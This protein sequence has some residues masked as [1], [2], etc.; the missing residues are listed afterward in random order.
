MIDGRADARFEA[1]R[2]AFAENFAGRGETGAAVCAFVGGRVV[3]DLWG[4]A[5]RPGL[6]WGPDTL[7]NV[8]SVGKGLT[9]LV[10]ARLAGDGRLDPDA[11]VTRYWPEFGAAG[12]E[13]VT[14]RH[15]LSHRAGL[16]A[17][18][19][20]LPPGAML[21][22]SAMTSALAGQEPWWEPGTAH[23]YHVNTFGFLVGEVIRRATGRTVG[24]LLR[25]E[26]CGPL[27]ADAF[28]G[29]PAA[30]HGRVAD[31]AWPGPPPPEDDPAGLDG[32]RLMEYN[33][34]FNPGGLSGA[35]VINSA[36]W[37][38]AELPST[39]AHASAR[40]VARVYAAL[41]AGGGLDGVRVVGARALAEATAERSAGRDRVLRRPSRFGS[42]FQLTQPER[43]LGPNLGAFG[44]YG[45]GGSLGFCDPAAGVAFGYVTNQLGPR[46][47]NPRN[48]ALVEA[49]YACL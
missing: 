48:R 6:P 15:L 10:A 2:A 32:D 34:Y 5:A 43:P 29:L 44:H 13:A 39:N 8:F 49:L 14:V 30:E 9:A 1:V 38:T 11:P 25:E 3:A 16:P 41:A 28:I 47:Q 19:R 4:G 40:G 21:D 7:V 33:A 23:G 37:R 22:W 46:W 17:V 36:S 35:G 12:K 27:G 45:A 24:T 20:R 18:R 42:G 31:F 26:V